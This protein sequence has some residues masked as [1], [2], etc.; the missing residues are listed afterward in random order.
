MEGWDGTTDGRPTELTRR[1]WQRF[2]ASGAAWMWGGEALAVR[3]DGRAN[4]HQLMLTDATAAPLGALRHELVRAAAAI[5]V[6]P[7]VGAQLTHSGRWARPD[8][9][10][11][12]PRVAF[13]HPILDLRSGVTSDAAVLSDAEIEDIVRCFG[14]AAYLAQEE[15]F[16]FVDVKHC[17]GYLAHE[18]LAAR[19]RTGAFGGAT[20]G[21]RSRL[22]DALLDAVRTAA[23]RLAIGVRLSAFDLVPYRRDERDD[24]GIPEAATVPYRTGFGVDPSA[25]TQPDLS[26]P[27]AL[28]RHLL[29]QGVRWLNVTAGS[30]YYTPHIQRPAAFPPSD[31]YRPPEDPLIGVAR[32]LTAARDVKAAVPEMIVVSSGWSYLQDFIPHVAQACVRDGWFDAVGLGRVALSYPDLPRDVL[33]GRGLDRRR[34]CRTF[35]DCTTAPRHGLVSGC[36]PLDAFYRERPEYEKLKRVKESKVQSPT[37]KV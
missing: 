25:P 33:E 22:L 17:H 15:G 13:R 37:S 27:I 2:G 23:P 14:R 1:R 21:A 36:Y 9:D 7:L 29:T 11:R 12:A 34:I 18:F 32:L 28:V 30:P 16:A 6:A 8:D 24:V 26:E 10:G 3:A 5:G 4:P 20:V 31:G 19:E 35:S